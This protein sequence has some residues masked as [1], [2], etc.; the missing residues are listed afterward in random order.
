MKNIEQNILSL[1]FIDKNSYVKVIGF[2]KEGVTVKRLREIGINE[3]IDLKVISNDSGKVVIELKRFRCPIYCPLS[4]SCPSSNLRLE[5]SFGE[6]ML[7]LV[8]K[9]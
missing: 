4:R 6:A 2:R 1:G 3:G 9:K 8:K 5:L 7:I